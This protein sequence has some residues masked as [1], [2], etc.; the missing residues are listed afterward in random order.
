MSCVCEC[1]LLHH[2]DSIQCEQKVHE[3]V[4]QNLSCVLQVEAVR[5]ICLKQ[6]INNVSIDTA[7]HL[8]STADLCTEPMLRDACTSSMALSKNR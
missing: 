8:Y 6:L 2:G 5:A 1:I 7:L 3:I 4:T